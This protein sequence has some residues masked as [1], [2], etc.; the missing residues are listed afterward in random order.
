MRP[1]DVNLAEQIHKFTYALS[2]T[3][4]GNIVLSETLIALLYRKQGKGFS[5]TQVCMYCGN[6]GHW[7]EN[8]VNMI[9]ILSL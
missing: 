1:T 2:Q 3:Y 4:A 9:K 8:D 6:T 7:Y 5:F